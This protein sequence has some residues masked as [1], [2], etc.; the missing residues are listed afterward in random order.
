MVEKTSFTFLSSERWIFLIAWNS[1][2]RFPVYS[3]SYRPLSIQ[4]DLPFDFM[5][6][7]RLSGSRADRLTGAAA[8][9]QRDIHRARRA[10]GPERDCAGRTGG[11]A[12][13]AFFPILK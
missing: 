7:H 2:G 9:A 6:G 3:P 4:H 11:R 8:D 13:P 10:I 12:F 1:S 5:N